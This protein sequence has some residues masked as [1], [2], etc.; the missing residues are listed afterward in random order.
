MRWLVG[1]NNTK[2]NHADILLR[3]G[4]V[5][6]YHCALRGMGISG[7]LRSDDIIDTALVFRPL[8]GNEDLIPGASSSI[9]RRITGS[10]TD[11]S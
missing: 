3:D 4:M 8:I 2:M 7:T 6:R 1:R 11:F 10:F 5:S 9:F